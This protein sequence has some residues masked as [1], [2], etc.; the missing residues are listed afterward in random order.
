MIALVWRPRTRCN[1]H[2][3]V[4]VC[5]FIL[6]QES[7]HLHGQGRSKPRTRDLVDPFRNPFQ[8]HRSES[9]L[10]RL[11]NVRNPEERRADFRAQLAA[12]ERAEERV[13]D[14]IDDH[15]YDRIR[16]GF[17]AVIDYSRARIQESIAELPDGTYRASDVLEG[18]VVLSGLVTRLPG[19]TPG[20]E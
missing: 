16:E 14:L 7:V 11:A 8:L 5:R 9:L 3:E 12:T 17:D 10:G 1:L 20:N 19:D 2:Q 15:G 18:D 6:S 4:A 13:A